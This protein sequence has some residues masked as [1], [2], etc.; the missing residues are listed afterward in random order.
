MGKVCSS[1]MV[2]LGRWDLR[3]FRSGTNA[4]WQ[5]TKLLGTFHLATVQQ[6]KIDLLE[7]LNNSV[8]KS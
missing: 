2:K 3:I 6:T 8:S 5:L 1:L 7:M 4:T